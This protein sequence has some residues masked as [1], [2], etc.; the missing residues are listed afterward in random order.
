[1]NER[2]MAEDLREVAVPATLSRG[3]PAPKGTS[4]WPLD[5]FPVTTQ[6]DAHG[7]L[8]LGGCLARD[9]AAEFGTPLYVYDGHTLVARCREARAALS[10]YPGDARVAY[11]SKAYLCLGLAQILNREGLGL[12]VV[13]QGEMAVARAAGFPPE[14]VHLHGNNKSRAELAA[15][16]EW[17]IGTIVVDGF[18]ELALLR[19]MLRAPSRRQRVWLRVSPGIDVHTHAHRKTG[20]L[21]TKFGFSLGNGGAAA[22]LREA[23]DV[24]GLQVVGLHAH[25]GSQV[26]ETAPFA[27]AAN[28][29][30]EVAAG[31]GFVPEE[32]SPGGGWGVATG[33]FEVDVP[34]VGAYCLPMASNYNLVPRPAVVLVRDGKSRL[35]QRREV[36]ADLLARD[37]PLDGADRHCSDGS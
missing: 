35:L 24:P 6:A 32:I 31:E 11:A 23:L 34:R 21:D 5:L 10:S 16:L 15:A 17:G 18:H 4:M 14:R 28:A 7:R 9:L 27:Q 36:T 37:V 8:R 33:K 13:S 1:M 3:G 29:L 22:G 20:L 30:I 19:E 12:D 2:G 26:F 25:I